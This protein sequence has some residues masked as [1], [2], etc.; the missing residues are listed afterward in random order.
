MAKFPEHIMR[1]LR[2]RIGLEPDDES[3]DDII[4][5]YTSRKAFEESIA[6][7]LGD[8]E[9]ADTIMMLAKDCGI[10]IDGL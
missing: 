5:N 6:W 7:W 1:D 3:K 2:N 4:N 8:W 9:W 10:K